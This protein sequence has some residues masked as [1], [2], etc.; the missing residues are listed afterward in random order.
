MTRAIRSSRRSTLTC[1]RRRGRRSPRPSERG[2]CR[3]ARSRSR[4]G[5]PRS[6]S[7]SGSPGRRPRGRSA[8]SR[9]QVSASPGSIRRKSSSGS[10]ETL[11][12]C[13]CCFSTTPTVCLLRRSAQ[14]TA[15]C[16]APA[17]DE[18]ICSGGPSSRITPSSRKQTRSAM[19]RA[20]RHL[21]RGD[22]HR[23]PARRELAHDVQHL[24][25]ELRVERARDLVEQHQLRPQRERAHDRHAL[26]LTAGE[27]VGVRV[28]L[29]RE[30]E[31]REQLVGA[32]LGL[33]A[34][35]AER[36]P[37]A[38]RDVPRARSCAGR[39][40]TTGRRSRSRGARG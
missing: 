30:P 26:L 20:K 14:G 25:D 28:A 32:R 21:V 7:R 22:Q 15:A 39:G 10:R 40:C 5:R 3:R 17:G 24:R 2:P 8:R 11:K 19:S 12:W 13:S 16:A 23:H 35:E 27:A 34:R 37:R 33:R 31:A 9:V 38:E 4:P 29:V 18:K 6:R 1:R 36:L